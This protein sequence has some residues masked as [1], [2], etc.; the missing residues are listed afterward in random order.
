MV[1]LSQKHF[2][3]F[4]IIGG[5]QLIENIFSEMSAADVRLCWHLMPVDSD[6]DS[7]GDSDS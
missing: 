4:Y 1:E 5:K 3:Y 2:E 7:D 6:S